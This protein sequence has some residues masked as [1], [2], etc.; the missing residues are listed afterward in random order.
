[1]DIVI[2]MADVDAANHYAKFMTILLWECSE[3]P[4]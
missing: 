1:M 2:T 3:I 4:L